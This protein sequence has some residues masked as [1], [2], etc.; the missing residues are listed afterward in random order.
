MK[1]NRESI[2]YDP[3]GLILYHTP[4]MPEGAHACLGFLITHEGRVHD[5]TLGEVPV[6]PAEVPLHND[7]LGEIEAKAIQQNPPGK[8]VAYYRGDD[9]RVGANGEIT[10]WDGRRLGNATV[11]GRWRT[12]GGLMA[13]HMMSF[14]ADVSGHRYIGRGCG[15]GMYLNLRRADQ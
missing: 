9:S 12:P 6:S 7:R 5:A 3:D 11:T 8:L 14:Q 2:V 1:L 10:T 15:N 4:D 13:S